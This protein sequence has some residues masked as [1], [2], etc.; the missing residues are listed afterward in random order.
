[1]GKWTHLDEKGKVD[2]VDITQKKVSFRKAEAQ[3]EIKLKKETIK[4]IKQ[5]KIHKG[6]VFVT[7][8]IAAIQAI[9]KTSENIPLCHNIPITD[10]KINFRTQNQKIKAKTSVKTTSKTGVEMEALNG[11]STALLTIWDMVKSKEKDEKGQ[12]P[13][14]K[15]ENIEVT[16]KMKKNRNKDDS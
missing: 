1:M 4:A 7:A 2:M 13:K 3:G 14:T 9:K 11:L 6:N 16:K 15:I 10:I 8:K 12:Y 5:E